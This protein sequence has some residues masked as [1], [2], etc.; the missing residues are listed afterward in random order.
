MPE[1]TTTPSADRPI[2]LGYPSSPQ[3]ALD[4]LAA[5][6]LS[7]DQAVLAPYDLTDPFSTLRSGE[8]DV[9]VVKFGPREDDLATSEVLDWE[10]RA[11]VV[12]ASHPL[13][14]RESVSV[15][16][17]AAYDA[18]ERPG[19]FP[20]YLWDEIVPRR[21]PQGREIRRRHRVN[22]IAEMMALVVSTDAVHLSVVSLADMAPPVV[23]V[24]PVPDLPP[25]P[26]CL[27]WHRGA[28]LPPQV[29]K[30]IAAV[31]A[32]SSAAREG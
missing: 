13:A 26:V 4:L 23:R 21:T 32:A 29:A 27:A 20:E 5:A 24:I 2:R 28:E 11:L 22:T 14:D 15:E 31:E 3:T 9:L 7:E 18:F 16:E 8:F 25:T 12:S 10:S 19:A 30:F 6:G 17:V 1:S